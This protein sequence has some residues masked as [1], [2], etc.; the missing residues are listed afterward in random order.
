M[1]LMTAAAPST[2]ARPASMI[3]NSNGGIAVQ[4]QPSSRAGRKRQRLRPGRVAGQPAVTSAVLDHV[5]TTE[6]PSLMAPAELGAVRALDDAYLLLAGL[7]DR[8]DPCPGTVL[9]HA[10]GLLAC[11]RP[12]CEGPY[13]VIHSP[14]RVEPCLLRADLVAVM[15]HRCPRC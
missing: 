15:A 13:S 2:V 7:S 6:P 10:D 11:N 3:S 4:H 1:I 5:D 12:G 8:P 9:S 14:D